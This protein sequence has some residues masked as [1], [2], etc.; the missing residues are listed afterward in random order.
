MTTSQ[1]VPDTVHPALEPAGPRPPAPTPMPRAPAASAPTAQAELCRLVPPIAGERAD[2]P[3]LAALRQEAHRLGG[4]LHH[5]PAAELQILLSDRVG[6]AVL[7]IAPKRPRILLARDATRY[8][9]LTQMARMRHYHDVGR[10]EYRTMPALA[11]A[12]GDFDRLVADPGWRRFTGAERAHA[13]AIVLN[14]GGHVDRA[15]LGD[16]L[17]ERGGSGSRAIGGGQPSTGG[18]HDH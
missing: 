18:G 7:D 5:S 11:R 3:F 15:E 17:A 2:G 12:Q 6:R 16:A 10:D 13:A 14:L 9:A 1:P 4:V 8:E